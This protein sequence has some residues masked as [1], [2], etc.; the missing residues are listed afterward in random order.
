VPNTIHTKRFKW[1]SIGKIK[2]HFSYSCGLVQI[3]SGLTIQE[4]I[5]ISD[6]LLYKAKEQGREKTIAEVI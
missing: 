3:E 5:K 2:R 6:D 1:P 4:T